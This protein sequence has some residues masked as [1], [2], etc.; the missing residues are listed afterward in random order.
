MASP[1]S[2][3]LQILENLLQTINSEFQQLKKELEATQ[4]ATVKESEIS[5][6]PKREFEADKQTMLSE[7]FFSESRESET[8]TPTAQN[9]EAEKSTVISESFFEEELTPR[10]RQSQAR[11]G[12]QEDKEATMISE[13]LFGEESTVSESL[14]YEELNASAEWEQMQQEFDP[15]KATMAFD[16]PKEEINPPAQPN[17][18]PSS[19]PQAKPKDQI[20]DPWT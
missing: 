2:E 3:R 12:F 19:Q 11:K 17:P 13:N 15:G 9:F 5:S 18:K 4:T 20:F 10:E 7:T 6:L 8:W 14:L 1:L 16:F